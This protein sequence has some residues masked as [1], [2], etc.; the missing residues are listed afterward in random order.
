MNNLIPDKRALGLLLGPLVFFLVLGFVDTETMGETA[1]AVLAST[2]WVAIWWIT[3]AV[4]LPI[5]S[6]LPVILLPLTGGLNAASATAAYGDRM[7]YLFLGGFII[8]TALEKWNLHRRIALKIILMVGTNPRSIIL[9]FMIA[10]AFISMWISNTATAMMMMPIGLAVIVQFTDFLNRSGTVGTNDQRFGK[11]L[12]LGIA[13]SASIGGMATLVGTPT[14]AVFVAIVDQLFDF[15]I[16]F[17]D[18]LFIAFPITV[19]LLFLCWFYLVRIAFPLKSLHTGSASAALSIKEGLNTE[20]KNEYLGLGKMKVEE[21]W[22]LAV[23]SL[24]AFAWI[25]R[26]YLLNIFVP[27]LDDTIIAITGA[28]LLFI[29]PSSRKGEAIL[30]WKTAVKIPWGILLLFGGG[31]AIAE[32]F[33]TSGLAN[34][35][36]VQL[37]VMDGFSYFL[38]FAIIVLIVNFLTEVTSNTA[39]ATMILPV[40]ASLALAL[41]V[42][43]FVLMAG[44][45]L[46]ASCAFMLPVATPPNAVVFGSGYV[47][48]QDM[49]KTGIWMNLL[50]ATLIILFIWFLMPLIWDINL[51]PFPEIFKQVKGGL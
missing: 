44:A 31:L 6:L 4:P 38:I 20:I 48:M 46:S 9:G 33:K 17:A 23:F 34:W 26:T 28:V 35:I 45:C 19:V 32:G 21:K 13:Y 42:H 41:D 18:W 30:D 37:S 40:M 12:M 36:G 51:Q 50:S 27:A 5:T 10:T 25:T 15:K 29:I 24:T 49:V 22:V 7:I 3:E 39:T 2:L 8:A 14:N 16:S 47:K 1:R 11:S 43:P